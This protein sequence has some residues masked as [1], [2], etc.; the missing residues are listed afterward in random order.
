MSPAVARDADA[1]MQVT[2]FTGLCGPVILIATHDDENLSGSGDAVVTLV[3]AE[4]VEVSGAGSSG[5]LDCCRRAR[6]SV[7]LAG[8][9]W[10][11]TLR[12]S[13]GREAGG[14]TQFQI[15]PRPAS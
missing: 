11:R 15:A 1:P 2:L 6:G 8:D 4:P 5:P 3:R 9:T 12:T 10:Q 14:G 7:S 13:I